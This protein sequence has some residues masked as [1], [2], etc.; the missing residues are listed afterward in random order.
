MEM[1]GLMAGLYRIC[2]WIYRFTVTNIL[3]FVCSIPFLFVVL[4]SLTALNLEDLGPFYSSLIL[5][6]V[7]APFTLFP[8]NGG[9]FTVVRKWI[10]GEED[11]PIFKTFFKGYKENYLQSVIGGILFVLLL[12]LFV[13]NYQFYLAMDNAM[14]FLSIFFLLLIVILGL[15]AFY[16]T[17]LMVHVHMKT[18]TLLKNSFFLTIG[19]P[20]TSLLI[21][22]VNFVLI[23][24]SL[25]IY[26]I[27]VLM[28]TG[29]FLAFATFYLF[30]RMFS[31]IQAKANPEEELAGGKN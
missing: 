10:M 8:A 24:F 7:V 19:R 18:L 1:N 21:A 5:L 3:W 25:F 15:A 9:L 4:M 28:V 23:Y 27:L 22:V 11:I 16:Y 2:E 20:I 31:K 26:Q 14:Q 6:A 30:Y 13:L 17:C 29:S 12:G